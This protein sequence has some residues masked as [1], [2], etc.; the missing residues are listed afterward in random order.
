VIALKNL[1]KLLLPPILFELRRNKDI[2]GSYLNYADALNASNSTGYSVGSYD[3]VNYV[4]NLR[5]QKTPNIWAWTSVTCL[6][7]AA[8]RQ[9]RNVL[10]KKPSMRVID[11]GGGYGETFFQFSKLLLSISFNVEWNI[12]ELADKVAIGKKE[13]ETDVLRF[14]E[15]I[16]AISDPSSCVLLL[17]GV[18]QYLSDP[19]ALIKE[20]LHYKNEFV[21][22]DR[23][24]MV[25]DA[26]RGFECFHV[27][28]I[29]TYLGGSSHP[30]RVLN[31][32]MV[33]DIFLAAGYE[34]LAQ[35]DYGPFPRG[36]SKGHYYAQVWHR[37]ICGGEPS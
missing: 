22:I 37:T 24:P 5:N 16:D 4:K 15:K 25:T 29:P 32:D 23:T 2:V 34:L 10:G 13:F 35:H 36:Y 26:R 31:Y 14:Y 33:Q 28:R 20:L 27:Q 11:W 1:L 30:L 3:L 18:L 7:I 8:T 9:L 21:A 6:L 17:G 12:V 19:Y